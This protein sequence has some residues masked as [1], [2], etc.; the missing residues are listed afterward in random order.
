MTLDGVDKNIET[1][2]GLRDELEKINFD[3]QQ[4]VINNLAMLKKTPKDISLLLL[5]TGDYSPSLIDIINIKNPLN[6]QWIEETKTKAIESLDWHKKEL[7]RVLC[8]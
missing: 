6:I 1:I 5:S 7:R 3:L 4:N 8:V 2:I